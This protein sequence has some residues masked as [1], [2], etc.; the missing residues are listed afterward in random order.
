MAAGTLANF[1]IYEEQFYGGYIEALEQNTDAFNGAS[2]GAI[3][4]TTD[5]KKGQYEQESFFKEISGLVSRRD[6]SS[7]AGATDNPL[8]QGEFV[9]VKL[10]RKIG[11]IANTMD[12][13]R[14]ISEDPE[15]LSFILGQ[16]IG[17]AVAVD[18]LN[19]AI[20][21]AVAGIGNQAALVHDGT[22][23]T[24]TH[25]A[26][27]DGMSKFG[28]ASN[29]IV[30]YVMH[31]KQYFDLVKQAIAD[32]IVEVAGVTIYT[33]NVATFN[34]PVIVTDSPALITTGLP[35][36]YHCLGLQAGGITVQESEGREILAEPVTGLENLMIRVQGEH[37]YN[38]GLRGYAWDI[39]NGGANPL[40]A[41][42][43][44]GTNW[45]KV[46]TDDKNTAGIM[47]N[48]Q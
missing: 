29:R 28:D 39:A 31:S 40:D 36:T 34:R 18:Y 20:A 25:T 5:R 44:T 14:K 9:R 32:K 7:V 1:Q 23:A 33:G 4:L 45:D 6:V 2:S 42:V 27:V 22:A 10:N 48:T 12:S 26:L 46:S 8:E 17:A 16:Q 11:P 43:A 13:F 21:A 24:I 19:T 15:E 3:S 35:D 47:V 37:A 38:L 41:A 30:A